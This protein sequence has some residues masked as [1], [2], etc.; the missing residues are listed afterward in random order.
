V[1]ARFGPDERAEMVDA[2][3]LINV[4]CEFCSKVFPVSVADLE[5]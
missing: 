3:G 5:A 1:L 2:K 4:D